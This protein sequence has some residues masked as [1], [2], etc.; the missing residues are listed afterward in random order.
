MNIVVVLIV[1]FIIIIIIGVML[2]FF[3]PLGGW[4]KSLFY[5]SA[6]ILCCTDDK[7]KCCGSACAVKGAV[8]P[9][10]G[11]GDCDKL[12]STCQELQDRI[13]GNAQ[14]CKTPNPGEYYGTN[15]A[16]SELSR[17]GITIPNCVCS[18]T[19]SNFKM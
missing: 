15:T 4:L 5:K 9:A 2:Y 17:E 16:C 3:T 14:C 8:C 7:G 12:D 18:K 10:C 6:F 13:S 19:V 11:V 1:L